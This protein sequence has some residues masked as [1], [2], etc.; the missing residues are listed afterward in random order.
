MP[1]LSIL[2]RRYQ[3]SIGSRDVSW[4]IRDVKS[5]TASGGSRSGIE[6]GTE[7]SISSSHCE[8]IKGVAV[9]AIEIGT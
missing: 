2:G 4:S 9:L 7:I 1:F 3:S 8:C 5:A 6:K